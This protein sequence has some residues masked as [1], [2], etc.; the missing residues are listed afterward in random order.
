VRVAPLLIDG[1]RFSPWAGKSGR[2]INWRDSPKGR[3]FPL[4]PAFYEEEEEERFRR[5]SFSLN[6]GCGRFVSEYLCVH[7]ASF[8]HLVK[9]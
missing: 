3:A 5:M 8:F 2:N 9:I 4:L 1:S 6:D 7:G